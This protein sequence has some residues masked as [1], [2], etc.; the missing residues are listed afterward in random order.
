MKKNIIFIILF[1]VVLG[2]AFV[3]ASEAE[4]Y[5]RSA[6]AQKELAQQNAEEAVAQSEL[7]IT[8][9]AEAENARAAADQIA[10]QLRICQSR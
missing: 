10:E 9:A 4:K 7:A 2:Y 8:R 6:V 5:R 3:K 1:L